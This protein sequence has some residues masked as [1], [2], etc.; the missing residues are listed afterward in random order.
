MYFEKFD[1]PFR[2]KI[3]NRDFEITFIGVCK[4]KNLIWGQVDTEDGV[5][6]LLIPVSALVLGDE[7]DV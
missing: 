1:E 5:I 4:E 6:D 3:N 2:R 7:K